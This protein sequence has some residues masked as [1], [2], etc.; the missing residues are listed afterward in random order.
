VR[1]IFPPPTSVKRPEDVL[2]EECYTI[3]LDTVDNL[4]ES[5]SRTAAVFRTK[6]GAA[7]N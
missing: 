3:P 1:N 6:G 4:N 5:I 7:L 2:E